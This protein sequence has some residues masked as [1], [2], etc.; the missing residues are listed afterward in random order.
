MSQSK[1]T[2][3]RS[4][5]WRDYLDQQLAN[6]EFRAAYDALE[7]EFALIRQ[8]IDLR[9]KRGLS[10]RQLAKRAKMQ[11]PTI[12]RLEGGQTASLRTLRRVADALDADVQVSLVPRKS[13][14]SPAAKMGDKPA[15]KG[16][17]R[18]QQKRA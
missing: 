7:P 9:V 14:G 17:K 13:S 2:H 1:T 6:P 10:Q 4:L 16:S 3:P 5:P 15:A 11:Q 12:A 8:L 18:S